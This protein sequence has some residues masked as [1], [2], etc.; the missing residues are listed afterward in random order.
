MKIVG[1]N[2][3]VDKDAELDNFQTLKRVALQRH[4]THQKQLAGLRA[5]R[6][7]NRASEQYFAELLDSIRDLPE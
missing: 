3:A 5:A 7:K 6:G 4:A 1:N 2:L